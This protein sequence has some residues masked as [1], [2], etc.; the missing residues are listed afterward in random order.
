[1]SEHFDTPLTRG[2]TGADKFMFIDAKGRYC[3]H[4]QIVQ[5]G[6]GGWD[7]ER[8]ERCG[9]AILRAVNAHDALVRAL[10]L[11]MDCSRAIVGASTSDEDASEAFDMYFAAQKQARAA[12]SKASP[13]NG[14]SQ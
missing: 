11:L 13:T 9:E 6:G 14:D 3:G 7:E 8:R 12:L 10:Q 5:T 4:V 1:M 2:K